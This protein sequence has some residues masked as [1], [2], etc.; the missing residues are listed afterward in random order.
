MKKIALF[1]A[2]C[3]FSIQLIAQ[4]QTFD[5]ATYTAP[6]GWKKEVNQ[7]LI[8]YTTVDET[9]KTW[10]VIGIVKST[11]SKGTIDADIESEWNELAVKQYHA[12]SMQTTATQEAEGWKVKAASGKF[13]AN[14]QPAV[15]LLTTFSGYE[16]CLSI[17]ATANSPHYLQTIENFLTTIELQKPAPVSIVRNEQIASAAN[18]KATGN[19][20]KFRYATSNFDNGWT[21][22][23]E[24]D[25]VKVTKGNITVLLH[26]AKDGTINAAD[27]VPHTNTAWN[28]L[29]APRY[30]NLQNYKVVSPSLDYQR[31]YLGA[32]NLTENKSGKSV[33]VA[34]F[35]KG[36]SNW[37]EIIA[38]DKN[39]FVKEFGADVNNIG[40][41]TNSAI[42]IP[43]LRLFTYNKFA[44]AASDLTGKWASWS[45]SNV[46]YVNAYTGL[47]AGMGHAQ[48]GNEFE[49]NGNGTYNR[50]YKGVSGSAGGGNRYY[51]EKSNGKAIVTNWEL[52]LTN[53]FKGETHVF[54]AQFEAIKG[55]RILHL[56][57][58]NIEEMHLY[59]LN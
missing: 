4:Q 32:G 10:C 52:Q 30:S 26:Y 36:N 17:L 51:G 24:T 27:P 45:G 9:K 38:P 28:I 13:I 58:G 56:Y 47:D 34:L 46:Q 23:E 19:S 48:N 12:D 43:L 37:V 44:V 8:T 14:S 55:G 59:K 1:I 25:W 40:W 3:M 2:V 41:D 5:L 6:K 21:A 15:I 50:E 42:W 31:A 7:T 35:R 22:T 18:K 53:S 20:G 16:R 33:Y 39:S 54:S 57:R 29:V 49:F 11:A